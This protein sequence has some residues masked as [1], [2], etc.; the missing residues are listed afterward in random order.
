[1]YLYKFYSVKTHKRFLLRENLPQLYYIM[2]K[3][4]PGAIQLKFLEV[5]R[6]SFYE[7]KIPINKFTAEIYCLL[8]TK[9]ESK[10]KMPM[11]NPSKKK[12]KRYD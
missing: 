11:T 10:L 8:K 9:I 2:F 5:N 3:K 6:Y 1:M 7:K 12:K 4:M